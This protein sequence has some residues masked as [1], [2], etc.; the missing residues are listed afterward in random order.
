MRDGGIAMQR[1][2][3][4][5]ALDDLLST[6][7]FT[8][9]CPNGLQVE[10]RAVVTRLATGTSA[11][12]AVIRKAVAAGADALLVHHGLFWR[13]DWTVTGLL[14]PRLAALLHSDCSLMAYHLPLDAHPTL[15]NNARL[16]ALA[17]AADEGAFGTWRGQVIGRRGSLAHPVT[18]AVF[19]KRL[20]RALDHPVV[21]CPGG[22]DRIRR[23]GA[24]SGGG[25]G[26][27]A[28]AAATGLD[29][30]I[31]GEVGEPTWHEAAELGIHCF[32][33]G[34][35]ATECLAVRELGERLA[36]EHGLDHI[37]ADLPNP[38]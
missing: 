30:L 7:G 25:A 27:L 12:L 28:E 14:K 37:D 5:Q 13:S 2:A 32:A 1:A 22:P 31:T 24:V 4:L 15:G 35:H 11:S 9:S 34:H 17:A 38:L 33:L 23:I 19:I 3:L 18:P 20:M 10:G 6:A 26:T 29:A 36:R 8:D 16:L 21:H